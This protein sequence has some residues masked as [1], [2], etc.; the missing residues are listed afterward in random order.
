[1]T[2]RIKHSLVGEDATRR[3]EIFQDFAFDRD[4]GTW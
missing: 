1:M 2:S 3:R 4:A